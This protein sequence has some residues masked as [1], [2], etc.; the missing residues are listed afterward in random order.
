MRNNQNVIFH[1]ADNAD[2]VYIAS[3]PTDGGRWNEV[4]DHSIL[5]VDEELEVH[6]A[7][8]T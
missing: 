6:T 2:A 8:L 3:E 4:P 7:G 1:G 5:V